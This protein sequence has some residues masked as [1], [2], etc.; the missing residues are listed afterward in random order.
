M[1][2]ITKLRDF[3]DSNHVHYELLS[4]PVTFTSQELAAVEHVRGRELAKV[5]VLRCSSGFM[6]A[7]LP[8][9]YHVD[10]QRARTT[11]GEQDLRLASEQEFVSLFP[12]CEPGAMPPFGNLYNLPVWVDESLTR[13]E[14]IVFNAGT[15]SQAIRM[16]YSDFARLAQ[17]KVGLLRMQSE[18]V[19][20]P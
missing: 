9:P 14:D 7:V 8:A 10:L 20:N 2:P 6:M 3:L 18:N 12:N 11:T 16:K 1:P 4:H 19:K 17:P 15:H 13:D 5:V